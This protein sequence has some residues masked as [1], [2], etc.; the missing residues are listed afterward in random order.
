M[1]L[2]QLLPTALAGKV[3]QSLNIHTSISTVTFVNR[4]LTLTFCTCM[5]NDQALKV[6]IKIKVKVKVKVMVRVRVSN[7]KQSVVLTLMHL[8]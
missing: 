4:P 7:V 3:M 6:K 8:V 2:Q 5:G 1:M